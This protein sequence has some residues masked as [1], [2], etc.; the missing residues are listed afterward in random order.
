MLKIQGPNNELFLTFLILLIVPLIIHYNNSYT[1]ILRVPSKYLMML[2]IPKRWT[3]PCRLNAYT[4][5][6]ICYSIHPE[7][8]QSNHP[9]CK[10]RIIRHRFCSRASNVRSSKKMIIIHF[11]SNN[12]QK[13]FYNL[14]HPS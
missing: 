14:T 7:Q 4:K 8:T 6:C 5:P 12:Y 9:E 1:A 11:L 10:H 13:Y 2:R 3:V